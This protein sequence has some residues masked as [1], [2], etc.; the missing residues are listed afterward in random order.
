MYCDSI[1]SSASTTPS[2]PSPNLEMNDEK[3]TE[4]EN[5]V[6]I[7]QKDAVFVS[8][9]INNLYKSIEKNGCNIDTVNNSSNE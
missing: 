2:P 3:K 5:Q 4:F 1:S 9:N 6:D 7:H 8:H